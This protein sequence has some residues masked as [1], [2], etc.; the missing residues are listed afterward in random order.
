MKKHGNLIRFQKITKIFIFGILKIGFLSGKSNVF[1]NTRV[2]NILLLRPTLGFLVGFCE[3][4]F[5]NSK[6]EYLDIS[7]ISENHL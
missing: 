1:K 4:M 7:K 5:P 2:E 6:I 3:K